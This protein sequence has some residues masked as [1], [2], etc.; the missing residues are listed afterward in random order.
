[1]TFAN[2]KEEFQPNVT[3]DN[4]LITIHARSNQSFHVIVALRRMR[5]NESNSVDCGCTM[6]P[7]IPVQN[8]FV[9]F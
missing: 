7:S 4:N 5:I 3:R 2:S 1:M 6:I 8:G 9:F